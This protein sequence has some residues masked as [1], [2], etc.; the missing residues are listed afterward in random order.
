LAFQGEENIAATAWKDPCMKCSHAQ[1][2][3]DEL[4]RRKEDFTRKD[5]LDHLAHCITCDNAYRT[6]CGIADELQ[7]SSES[8]PPP[9]FEEKV[10]RS[11]A[12]S[13]KR[14]LP[15]PEKTPRIS[16]SP[17]WAAVFLIIGTGLFFA[18]RTD[19]TKAVPSAAA[20]RFASQV[21]H[22]EITAENAKN[23]ALVGDFNGWDTVKNLLKRENNGIWVIDLPMS[24]GSYAYLFLI[25]GTEWR[26]DPS[27]SQEIPDGFGGF[28]S[29][30]E[31]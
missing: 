6:W 23:V 5:V 1:S 28:N 10:L 7:R 27:Q 12:L 24:K 30:I 13:K 22:F 4:Y 19:R 26:T 8:R 16:F 14:V 25:D 21:V 20:P 18:L 3:F 31:L 15:W 17:A 9:G 29:E 2:F 11:I